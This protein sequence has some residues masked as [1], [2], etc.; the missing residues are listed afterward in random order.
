[1]SLYHKHR[2]TSLK[3][4]HGNKAALHSLANELAKP[5][6]AMNHYFLLTGLSGCGKTTLAR[7]IAETVGADPGDIH[8]INAT[9]YN[10][11][12]DAEEL[13]QKLSFF[14]MY[15]PLT[16][17]FIDEVQ[18]CTSGWWNI[19]LKYLEDTPK[20][21]VFILGT[22]EAHKV[23][24]LNSGAAF[25]RACHVE[26]RP[27]TA[28]QMFALL[29][30][31]ISAEGITVPDEHI[32][33]VVNAADGSPRQAL[34]M[35]EKVI[36]AKSLKDVESLLATAGNAEESA[37]IKDLCNALMKGHS[38]ATAA[39]I[40]AKLRNQEPETIRRGVI[41]YLSSVALSNGDKRL[42]DIVG[43]WAE[44]TTYDS[45]FATLVGLLGATTAD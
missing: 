10:K 30:D 29:D 19:M 42:A 44:H 45:G 31:V 13:A 24:G 23:R 2:P 7:I 28:K 8:E 22:S 27:L 21:V 3:A 9:V 11:K 18:I 36:P 34:T 14:P 39:K 1:M 6:D 25:N 43:I 4:M 15:G 17:Y 26:V 20:H 37:E 32:Q 40:L 12:E 41:G 35:L 38:F 33:A 16:V 5:I